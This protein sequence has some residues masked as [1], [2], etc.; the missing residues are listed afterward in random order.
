MNP[1]NCRQKYQR[2]TRKTMSLSDECQ[3]LMDLQKLADSIPTE[4]GRELGRK[5]CAA[6]RENVGFARKTVQIA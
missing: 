5:I 3:K 4:R 6:I 1:N 2:Y